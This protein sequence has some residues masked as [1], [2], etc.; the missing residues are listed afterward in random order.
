[1]GRVTTLGTLLLAGAAAGMLILGTEQ[2]TRLHLLQSALL[3]VL[4]IVQ[5]KHWLEIQRIEALTRLP[6]RI[7]LDLHM[8]KL[9]AD[10]FA[11][12]PAKKERN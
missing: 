8:K 7:D 1:M 6:V 10:P 12:P 11:P 5:R 9:A 2:Q 3:L 4:A